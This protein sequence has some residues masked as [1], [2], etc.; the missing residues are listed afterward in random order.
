MYNKYNPPPKTA[1]KSE[2]PAKVSDI[3]ASSQYKQ[4]KQMPSTSKSA[5]TVDK[6]RAVLSD[7]ESSDDDGL[8]NPNEIDFSSDFFTKKPTKDPQASEAPPVFDCNAGVHLSDSSDED[9]DEFAEVP[10]ETNAT[11]SAKKP[12]VIDKINKKS[13]KE[14]HDFSTLQSFAKNLESA[15]AQLSKLKEKD[16]MKSNP[17]EPDITKLL[18]LGEGTSMA[19]TSAGTPSRKRK[20]KDGQNSDDSDWENVSGKK[21]KES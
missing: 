5:S 10:S 12:S 3:L 14:M 15:K 17:D 13:S 1:N 7:S 20:H 9:N 11:D 19:S 21:R 18:S 4:R 8:V 2:V 16:S 6:K